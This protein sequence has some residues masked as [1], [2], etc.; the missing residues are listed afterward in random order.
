[1]DGK[2]KNNQPLS[3]SRL[4]KILVPVLIVIVIAGIYLFKNPPQDATKD[5]GI[6]SQQPAVNP[7]DGDS[8]SGGID[9]SSSEFDL[10][11]TKDFDFEKILSYGLPVLI[12]F[13]SDT[14]FPCKEMAPILEELNKELRGKAIVKFVDIG[15]NMFATMNFP[16]SYIPTQFFFDKDGNPYKPPENSRGFIMY[17]DK[18]EKHVLTAHVGPMDKKQMMAVFKELGVE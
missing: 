10:D 2:K 14:C 5:N 4:I 11:A 3:N 7:P 8:D 16:V 6:I 17:Q 1:M 12:D 18:N 15:K 9:Y 13:G